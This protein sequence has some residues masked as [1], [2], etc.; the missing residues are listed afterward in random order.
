M[1]RLLKMFVAMSI[2]I[3]QLYFFLETFFYQG[4]IMPAW[5]FLLGILSPI[6]IIGF[7]SY[8]ISKNK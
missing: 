6:I 2:I 8:F 1:K 3:I 4:P 5:R 7:V